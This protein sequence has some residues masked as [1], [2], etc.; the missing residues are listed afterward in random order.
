MPRRASWLGAHHPQRERDAGDQNPGDPIQSFYFSLQE[1]ESYWGRNRA[2]HHTAPIS[3]TYALREALRMM[4]EEGIDNRIDRH[5]RVAAGLRA[6][7]EALG[8][9][10]LADADYRL[11]PLT[12]VGIRR[13]STMPPRGGR[14]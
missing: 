4:M 14:C 9:E 8:L 5:A 7:L 2:Y 3:M 12:T 1:L 11:N 6:G 10:L 13:A